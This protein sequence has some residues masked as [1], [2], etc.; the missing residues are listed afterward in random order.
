VI[1]SERCE[2]TV[3]MFS[4]MSDKRKRTFVTMEQRLSI[5]ERLDKGE[6]VQSICITYQSIGK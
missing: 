1:E 2:F 5:L 3:K 6:S 4:K